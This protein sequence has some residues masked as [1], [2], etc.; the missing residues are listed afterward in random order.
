MQESSPSLTDPSY[1]PRIGVPL[2]RASEEQAQDREKIELYLKAIEAAGGKP[3]LIS[4]FLSTEQLRQVCDELDGVVLPGSP[5]DVDPGEYG[6]RARP[7]TTEPDSYREQTDTSLLDWAF[8]EFKPVLAICFGIQIL[9]V[10]RHGTLVQ[11]IR[12]ELRS[13]L[14]HDWERESGVP[15][16]HH[17]VRILPG[18]R[19]ALLA[20][21]TEAVV[22]SSHHQSIGEPGEG[23]RVTARSPDG[24]VEAVELESASHWVVGVQWHPER[25][26]FEARQ[27]FDSGSRL[28]EALFREL[29]R[30]AAHSRVASPSA[31]RKAK[32]FEHLEGK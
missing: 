10:Y 18:S 25:Q 2:R 3:Q 30:A 21:T 11:D 27:G 16:P 1:L 17:P 24:V 29:V 5:A 14:K 28:S 32:F 8:Q 13:A 12:A 6:Q 31:S 9:N 26:Q 22:N 4:L 19:L 20:E 7:E 23:L 15:E